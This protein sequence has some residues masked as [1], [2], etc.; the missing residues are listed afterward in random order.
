MIL[1]KGKDYIF[2]TKE[3]GEIMRNARLQL[4]GD[5]TSQEA[6]AANSEG[7]ISTGTISHLENG[8]HRVSLD[9]LEYW[10]NV[11][12]VNLEELLSKNPLEEIDEEDLKF[13]LVAIEHTLDRVDIEEGWR[14]LNQLNL[15][16]NNPLLSTVFYLKGKYFSEKKAWDQAYACFNKGVDIAKAYQVKSKNNI[17]SACYYELS[18]VALFKNDLRKALEFTQNGLKE[19]VK[20]G[21][22]KYCLY[23]LQVS[24][25]IYLKNLN[26]IEEA[27]V[28]LDELNK[29]KSDIEATS[30]LLNMADLQAE[31]LNR[32]ERYEEATKFALEGIELARIENNFDRLFDLWT[33]LGTSYMYLKQWKKAERCLLEALKLKNKIK[34]EYLP[35]KTY[36]QLGELYNI[37]DKTEKAVDN[38]KKAVKLGKKTNDALR[39][40]ESLT[41]LGDCYFKQ[42]DFKCA[43]YEY[44]Q[45]LAL[46]ERHSFSAQKDIL[47]IKL[48][49]CYTTQG[50]EKIKM[51]S[52][53]LVAILSRL[54]GRSEG[55]MFKLTSQTTSVKH[56]VSDPPGS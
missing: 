2:I 15:T 56:Y 38:L 48:V 25:V 21:E 50:S 17:I 27:L 44:E 23:F 22:R 54:Q 5:E 43:E 52:D 1:M 20:D 31:L 14:R 33:V 3:M 37:L 26:R 10:C 29:Q 51:F 40:C 9:K 12:K 32:T 45:A 53:R 39:T 18:R 41:S 24:K 11:V 42:G 13:E 7:K 49:C 19:F 4:K 55:D 36:R 6:L 16:K 46:A 34:Q 8:G 47:V 28:A 30:V 35:V